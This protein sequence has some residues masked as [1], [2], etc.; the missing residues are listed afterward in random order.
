MSLEDTCESLTLPIADRD[1]ILCRACSQNPDGSRTGV[2]RN[3]L[4]LRGCV[5]RNTRVVAGVVVY[6]GEGM[7]SVRNVC[8]TFTEVVFISCM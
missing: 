5:L 6:A 7:F 2:S 1:C 3:N 8:Y 4:L